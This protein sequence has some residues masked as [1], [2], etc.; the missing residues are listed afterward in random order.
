MREHLH[1]WS[2]ITHHYEDHSARA[3]SVLPAA[4]KIV[5][6]RYKKT[7]YF[8]NKCT[9]EN[10]LRAYGAFFTGLPACRDD[11]PTKGK[12]MPTNSYT[13]IVA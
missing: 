9:G 8:A 10:Y 3:R 2:G 13:K 12:Q 6:K 11:E 4:T 1:K 5:S 7:Y